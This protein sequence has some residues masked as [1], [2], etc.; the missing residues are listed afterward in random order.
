MLVLSDLLKMQVVQS[1]VILKKGKGLQF[2]SFYENMR[3]LFCEL[4]ASFKNLLPFIFLGGNEY[5]S[6][7][8]R[9]FQIMLMKLTDCNLPYCEEKLLAVKDEDRIKILL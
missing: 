1:A 5:V 8:R 3:C 7:K 2:G 6:R 4:T 9:A